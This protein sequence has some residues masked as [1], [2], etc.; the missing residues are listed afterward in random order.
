MQFLP[1]ALSIFCDGT[2][3]LLHL[4]AKQA[5]AREAVIAIQEALERL[6]RTPHEEENEN[7]H[8]ESHLVQLIR[9]LNICTDCI[10]RLQLRRKGPVE[11][12]KPIVKNFKMVIDSI[13]PHVEK[14]DH[15]RI[16]SAVCGLIQSLHIWIVHN[17]TADTNVELYEDLLSDFLENTVDA[18]ASHMEGSLAQYRLHQFKFSARFVPNSSTE[19]TVSR[20][21]Q[22]ALETAKI[23]NITSERLMGTPFS[24]GKLILLAYQDPSSIPTQPRYLESLL[25]ILI[26][27]LQQNVAT[28]STLAL[29]LTYIHANS[30]LPQELV[31]PL[32]T[33][34]TPF[35]SSHPDPKVRYIAFRVLAELLSRAPP[36]VHLAHLSSLLSDCPFDQMR[37]AA[38]GL[39]R[40]AFL[41]AMA[42]DDNSPFKT[43]ALLRALG[44]TLFRPNPPDLFSSLT[45]KTLSEF[46]ESSEPARLTEC[47][48]FYYVLLVRDTK[49]STGIRDHDML[50]TVETALLSPLRKALET[51]LDDGP[52]MEDP[53]VV[54]AFAGLETCV[55]RVDEVLVSIRST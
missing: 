26:S 12:I 4:I 34:L 44:P 51:W 24:I 39:V 25:Y 49:N 33:I 47:L 6:E 7:E 30:Q 28:D 21:L 13:A 17:A 36:P 31:D 29:L 23:L 1:K 50:Q 45:E 46:L 5:S 9:L 38:V 32:A 53:H 55:E 15:K 54:M 14:Q 19:H 2:S 8:E 27:C 41:K 40:E 37:V 20:E 42:S 3:D 22:E 16:I 11:T 18:C 10:P 48:S 35:S 43:N 52:H